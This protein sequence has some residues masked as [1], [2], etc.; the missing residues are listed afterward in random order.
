MNI[1]IL[2]RLRV[3]TLW[4]TESN[5]KYI[6]NT[7]RRALFWSYCFSYNISIGCVLY[8]YILHFNIICIYRLQWHTEGGIFRIRSPHPLYPELVKRQINQTINVITFYIF[9]NK[10][11]RS[12]WKFDSIISI[13]VTDTI[14][15]FRKMIFSE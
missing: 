5:N 4:Q 7:S 10:I 6:L 12:W 14:F 8:I 15:W 11:P 1:I 9:A 13:V 2:L 3:T